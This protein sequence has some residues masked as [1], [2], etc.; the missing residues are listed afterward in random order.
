MGAVPDRVLF[1]DDVPENVDAARS[2]GLHAAL[3]TDDAST[4]AT[5]RAATAAG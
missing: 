1:L 3:H 4:L 5:I 2:L